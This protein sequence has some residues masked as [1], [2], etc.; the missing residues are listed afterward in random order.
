MN[1][2]HPLATNTYVAYIARM[3]DITRH[4]LLHGPKRT[5]G[6]SHDNVVTTYDIRT[7]RAL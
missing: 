1:P 5:V 3:R 4:S 2:D 7:A 6:S